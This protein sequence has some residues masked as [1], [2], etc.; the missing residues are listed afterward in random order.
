M[1][2]ADAAKTSPAELQQANELRR[3]TKKSRHLLSAQFQALE[4][5]GD[6]VAHS[7]DCLGSR[8]LSR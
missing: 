4:L 6:K 8:R 5:L 7:T 1:N 2:V 3:E